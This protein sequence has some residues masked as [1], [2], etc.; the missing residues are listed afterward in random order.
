MRET[1]RR[2]KAMMSHAAVQKWI[3]DSATSLFWSAFYPTESHRN[4]WLSFLQK[5]SCENP[6][7][8]FL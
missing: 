7:R 4:W 1:I 3:S 6:V 2:N 5:A 8:P